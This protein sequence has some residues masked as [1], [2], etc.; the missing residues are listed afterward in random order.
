MGVEQVFYD[1]FQR[2]K[3]YQKSQ[4]LAAKSGKNA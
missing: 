4:E 1:A 2:A 3:E